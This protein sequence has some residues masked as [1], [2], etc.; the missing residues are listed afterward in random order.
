VSFVKK[1]VRVGIGAVQ[2]FFTDQCPQ[3]AAAIAYRVLFSIAPLAIVLVSIFG[4]V[5]QDDEIRHDVVKA[6]VDALPVSIAGR[7]D[8]EDAI[9]AIATP[10]TAAGL[11]SLLLFAWAAT[12][13]MT[14]IRKGLEHAMGVT[15]SRPLARGKLVDLLLIVGAAVLTLVIV[16]I[17]LAGNFVHGHPGRLAER[18]GIG[19]GV[20]ADVVTRAVTFAL[21]VFVVLLL[22]RFVPARGLRIRDG[23]VGAVVTAICLQLISLASGWIYDKTSELSVIYGSLTAVLVFLYSMYLTAAALL[24]GAETAAGWARPPGPPGD[25]ALVQ[26]RRAVLGLFVSQKPEDQRTTTSVSPSS[27]STRTTSPTSAPSAQRAS[28]SSP[29]S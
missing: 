27:D 17:T 8:V 28:Q 21:A 22:Y 18:I 19:G 24:L 14:A 23:V 6:I 3:Y 1:L 12:G 2:Q 29:R 26:V 16:A 20:L 13:M 9:T 4:L 25:P 7:K 15:E 10:A 5:L 11:V